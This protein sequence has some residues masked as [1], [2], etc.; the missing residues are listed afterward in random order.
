MKIL[1]VETATSWQSVALLDG[2][3]VLAL[4]HEEAGGAHARKLLPAIDRLLLESGLSLATLDGLAVSIGPGSF[5]GLR[6]GLAT[7]MGFRMIT[8][9]PLAS[10]PTLEALAWNFRLADRLLCPILR[11]RTGAVYWAMYRWTTD[12]RLTQII[13]EQVGSMEAL[14]Q[15]ITG[16]TIVLGEGWLA[17]GDELRRLLGPDAREVVEAP[18][19]AMR[20]S[21]VSVGL[22]GLER[23]ARQDLAPLGLS[24][25]YVQRPEAELK[26]IHGLTRPKVAPQSH[27]AGSGRGQG[28]T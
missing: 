2:A 21:A 19:E 3:R 14:A 5:T 11:A 15:S 13:G 23:L 9:L 16:P 27:V 10:V 6:V 28:S 4:S 17:Y 1:A 18:Q 8:G 22:A 7:M 25:R 24:P 20:A 26:E 12:G